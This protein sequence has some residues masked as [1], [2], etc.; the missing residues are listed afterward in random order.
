MACF[1][2][3]ATTGGGSRRMS[4]YTKLRTSSVIEAGRSAVVSDQVTLDALLG[5]KCLLDSR[6]RFRAL[7]IPHG[8]MSVIAW[9]HQS[10]PHAR[11]FCLL[12]HAGAA[13]TPRRSPLPFVVC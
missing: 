13:P 8:L 12:G 3:I 10:Q 4:Q 5:W 7:V 11:P 2:V 9:L 6:G 1:S